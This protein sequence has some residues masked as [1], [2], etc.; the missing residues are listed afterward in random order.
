MI[1]SSRLSQRFPPVSSFFPVRGALVSVLVH[2]Y[3]CVQLAKE[4]STFELMF[5]FFSF[6]EIHI[7]IKYRL[8]KILFF[9]RQKLAQRPVPTSGSR[10]HC[11]PRPER[12]QHRHQQ[13]LVLSIRLN[14]RLRILVPRRARVATSAKRGQKLAHDESSSSFLSSSSSSSS[15]P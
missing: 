9:L 2:S 15:S 6:L 12:L 11:L 10:V 5:F 8:T 4:S 7:L 14:P 3:Q 13:R 1:I